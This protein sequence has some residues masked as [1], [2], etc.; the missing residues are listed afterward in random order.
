MGASASKH[1]V[2]ECW[3]VMPC[4]P[5]PPPPQ[6][7]VCRR[8]VLGCFGFLQATIGG[9]VSLPGIPSNGLG[10]VYRHP[11]SKD[12]IKQRCHDDITTIYEAFE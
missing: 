9:V 7:T 8:C 3:T 5:V 10:D 12:G 6:E 4:A 11:I 2:R 1:T